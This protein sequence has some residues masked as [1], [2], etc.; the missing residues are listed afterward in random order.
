MKAYI[1]TTGALFLLLTVTHVVRVVQESHL[2]RDPFFLV[3]TVV[4]FALALW[5]LRLLTKGA[6]QRGTLR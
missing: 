5:A 6:P 2:A 3:A 1:A 4:A